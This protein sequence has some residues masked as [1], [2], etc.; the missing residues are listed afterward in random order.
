MPLFTSRNRQNSDFVMRS[1]PR[2]TLTPPQRAL[3]AR[4]GLVGEPVNEPHIARY[5]ANEPIGSNAYRAVQL[6]RALSSGR[7]GAQRRR[8]VHVNWKSVLGTTDK[9]E[10]NAAV[11]KARGAGNEA[12][13]LSLRGAYVAMRKNQRAEQAAKQ[14]AAK[15]RLRR[16]QRN[17][18]TG[19]RSFDPSTGLQHA[20]AESNRMWVMQ[21]R[22]GL[23]R[24]RLVRDTVA[25]LWRLANNVSALALRKSVETILQELAVTKGAEFIQHV[26][27][28]RQRLLRNAA[29]LTKQALGVLMSFGI[30]RTCNHIAVKG[31]WV[32]FALW[33]ITSRLGNKAAIAAERRFARA[34]DRIATRYLEGTNAGRVVP[35]GI[36]KTPL[37]VL[38]HLAS[39]VPRCVLSVALGT[40][41]RTLVN[42]F[43]RDHAGTELD[44]TVVA[45]VLLKH[46][47]LVETFLLGKPVS[48]LPVVVDLVDAIP[49]ELLERVMTHVQ[50]SY[51]G[52]KKQHGIV[53]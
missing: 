9:K 33:P 22:D 1:R 14:R 21:G 34:M 15:Q 17:R 53:L 29:A 16:I 23:A 47:G 11:V 45:E 41:V 37:G 8:R 18:R 28:S 2:N 52:F 36:T 40:L 4:F 48:L 32:M 42:G 12:R 46:M 50:K 27:R 3:L 51:A 38:L 35:L 24:N 26:M 7:F 43:L 49:A 44:P 25:T 6:S 5:Y 19:I 13:V 10:Y 31:A 39:R 30:D 20:Q